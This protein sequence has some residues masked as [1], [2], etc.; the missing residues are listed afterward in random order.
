[1]A[2]QRI[3]LFSTISPT[4]VDQSAGQSLRALAGLSEQVG[5]I[6]FNIG[7]EKRQKE[8]QI[9]GADVQRDEE[10]QIVAPELKSDLTIFG[11]SFNKSAVLAYKAQIGLDA[12]SKLEELQNTHKL[13]PEAFKQ[14][15]EAAKQGALTKMPE[16][17]AIEAGLEYDVRIA[18][19]YSALM[20]DFYKRETEDQQ[21]TANEWV[22]SATD[23]ILNTARSGDEQLTQELILANNDKLEEFVNELLISPGKVVQLKERLS[24]NIVKQKTLGEIDRIVF[25][26]DFTL[27]EKAQKGAEFLD[28]LRTQDFK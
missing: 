9:A 4:G 2:Q 6:A 22:E 16:E 3:G 18:N 1:M 19:H 10:G 23:D 8:G 20:K 26:D 28:E 11:E 13:D 25:S 5:D 15:A 7:A 21:A 14:Q 27:E 24:E 12:K 17:I